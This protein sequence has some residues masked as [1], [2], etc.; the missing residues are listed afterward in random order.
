M[1]LFKLLALLR[2]LRLNDLLSYPSDLRDSEEVRTW[3]SAVVDALAAFTDL[4]ETEVDDE[5]ADA[6]AQVVDND[7]AWSALH[8]LLISMIFDNVDPTNAN[9]LQDVCNT[10]GFNPMLILA[11]IQMI[12]AILSLRKS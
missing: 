3:V 4:T 10:T 7:V 11:I 5:I 6:I 1:V 9:V 2:T 12:R 8:T